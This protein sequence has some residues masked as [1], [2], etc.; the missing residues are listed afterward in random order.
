MS[1]GGFGA[2]FKFRDK[3]RRE[4]AF[5]VFTRDVK[6]R[7]WRYE[8]LHKTLQITQFPFMFDFHYVHE[9]FKMKGAPYPVVMMEW[10]HGLQLDAA[11]EQDLADDGIFQCAPHFAGDLFT[12]VKTLQE[13]NM[14]HNDLQ[15]CNGDGYRAG[16]SGTVFRVA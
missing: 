11:V 8:A 6:G 14:R 15:D 3:N 4:Y 13:W 12:I 2:I 7:A 16:L 10:G 5:K 9:G 1:V